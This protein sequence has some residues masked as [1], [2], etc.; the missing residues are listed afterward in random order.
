MFCG[1]GSFTGGCEDRCDRQGAVG[2][3]VTAVSGTA[4]ERL[5]PTGA[6]DTGFHFPH[7]SSG[8]VSG[9]SACA[10][11]WGHGFASRVWSG[12][13]WTGADCPAGV[14]VVA[15]VAPRGCPSVK[16]TTLSAA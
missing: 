1:G 16:W 10:G 2:V 13:T 15:G 4:C 6:T 12:S 9:N 7:A 8:S 14:G 3:G 5:G 11:P